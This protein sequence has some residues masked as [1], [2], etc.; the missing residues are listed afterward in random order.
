MHEPSWRPKVREHLERASVSNELL[1]RL[2]EASPEEPAA[3]LL[4]DL[5]DSGRSLLTQV[6]AEQWGALDVDA[7]VVGALRKIESRTVET[8]LRAI[9]RQLPVASE[10]EKTELLREKEALSRKIAELNPSRWNVL[11]K[12]R[13]GS[14]R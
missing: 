8:R 2:A 9:D 14:A 1:K 13:S 7:I 3:A 5:D 11:K 10:G 12:R 6:M 4:D